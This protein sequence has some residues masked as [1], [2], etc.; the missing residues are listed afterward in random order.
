MTRGE[1]TQRLIERNIRMDIPAMV[2]LLEQGDISVSDVFEISI[3]NVNP[4]SWLAC[5][6][7]NHYIDNHPHALESML[8]KAVDVLPHV[9]RTGLVRLLL[10]CFMVT[11]QWHFENL[12]LLLNFSLAAVQNNSFPVAVKANA[13]CILERIAKDYPDASEEITLVV[14]E[15]IPYLSAG[16]K[17]R[18]R[19]L[20]DELQQKE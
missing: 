18:A 11:P 9:T 1:F 19:K 13:M 5:W 15:Q 20:L 17:N 8:G 12:G 14:Q 10:R 16:G 4:Q 3:E 7:L 2:A 6:V